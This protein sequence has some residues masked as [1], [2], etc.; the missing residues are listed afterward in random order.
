[1]IA[2]VCNLEVGEFV[3]TI[4]DA[5]IYLNHLKQIDSM[6]VREPRPLPEIKILR[7]VDSIFDFKYEDFELVG[8]VPHPVIK[9][10]V[11]V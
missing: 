5:H 10:E 3:H 11:A 4:G 8:Y 6:L 9:A 2:H 1:M 7:K